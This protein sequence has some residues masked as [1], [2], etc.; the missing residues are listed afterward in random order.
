MQLT[1]RTSIFE[2]IWVVVGLWGL[3][4]ALTLRHDA[5]RDVQARV[6][7]G[8]NSGKE[9]LATM[10]VTTTGLKAAA[11]AIFLFAGV[12]AAA[13]LN[14]PVI[15]PASA[16]I[17]SLLIGGHLLL[18]RSLHYQQQVRQRVFER[19]V[20][21]EA[22]RLSDEA[23]HVA[24]EAA[25]V[26]DAA[27]RVSANMTDNTEALHDLTAA[28]T[29]ATASSQSQAHQSIVDATRLATDA[30][31][32]AVETAKI[33]VSTAATADSTAALVVAAEAAASA[34][35]SAAASAEST[36]AAADGATPPDEE[37]R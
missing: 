18:A 21:A 19:D 23:E 9:D 12:A 26:S 5:Q 29:A 36:L 15:R 35:E 17:Q 31:K 22:K 7:S 10:L 34:A 14:P 20:R 33:A 30:A 28:T 2:V 11:F 25:R 32:T 24:Q 16:F 3:Y 4:Q 37:V 27:A 8:S 13:T 6:E 1:D